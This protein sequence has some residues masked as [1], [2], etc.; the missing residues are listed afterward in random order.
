VLLRRGL[1]VCAAFA[2]VLFL[3]A[4]ISHNSDVSF[5]VLTDLLIATAAAAGLWRVWQVWLYRERR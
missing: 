3:T 1:W 4:T 5:D 2:A